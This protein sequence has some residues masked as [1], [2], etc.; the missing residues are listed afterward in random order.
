MNHVCSE[1]IKHYI[2]IYIYGRK[3]SF[4]ALIYIYMCVGVLVWR[5]DKGSEVSSCGRVTGLKKRKNS[6]F[7]TLSVLYE[8]FVSRCFFLFFFFF[9][10]SS[11]KRCGWLSMSFFA[12]TTNHR[13]SR[14]LTFP[15]YNSHYR[16]GWTMIIYI[17][18]YTYIYIYI[19]V[20]VCVCVWRIYIYIYI[21]IDQKIKGK[22]Q[23]FGK[24]YL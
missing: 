15:Q 10:I 20:C 14:L 4:I 16:K 17:Y 2:Y 3:L 23:L 1:I 6:D 9:I 7:I 5:C 18:I 22:P 13:C 24:E 19:C 21:H 11:S 12:Q 8:E